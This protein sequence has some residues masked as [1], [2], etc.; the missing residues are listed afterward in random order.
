MRDL[1]HDLRQQTH[2]ARAVVNRLAKMIGQI[3]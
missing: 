3:F 2:F 1:M